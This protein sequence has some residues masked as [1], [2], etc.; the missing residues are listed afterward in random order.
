MINEFAQNACRECH[1]GSW[2]QPVFRLFSKISK[3]H[4]VQN[5]TKKIMTLLWRRNDVPKI[6]PVTSWDISTVTSWLNTSYCAE[7]PRLTVSPSSHGSCFWFWFWATPGSFRGPYGM[8]GTKPGL[9][10]YKASYLWSSPT[11][12]SVTSRRCLIFL[13]VRLVQSPDWPDL[14][15]PGLTT[16]PLFIFHSQRPTFI[17][18]LPPGSWSVSLPGWHPG[19]PKTTTKAH[20]LWRWDFS[21]SLQT[22]CW[23]PIIGKESSMV[24]HQFYLRESRGAGPSTPLFY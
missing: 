1:Q 14:S 23:A 5:R 10:V 21:T 11:W 9:A 24:A 15:Q 20:T 17:S 8:L 18:Q 22:S 3:R 7:G 19:S 6:H 4:P 13:P 12:L 2:A 16:H